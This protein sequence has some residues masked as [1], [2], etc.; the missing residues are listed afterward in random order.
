[1]GVITIGGQTH[2]T[3]TIMIAHAGTDRMMTIEEAHRI[4]T[5]VQS[6]VIKQTGAARVIVHTV[7]YKK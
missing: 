2:I 4:A 5:D 6:T 3:L 1:M 7:P